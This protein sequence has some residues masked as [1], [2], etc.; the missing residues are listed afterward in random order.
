MKH[1]N[2][3]YFG[4]VSTISEKLKYQSFKYYVAIFTLTVLSQQKNTNHTLNSLPG[5][6]QQGTAHER[7]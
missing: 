5:N 2:L 4:S 1:M 7:P 3:Q 6:N